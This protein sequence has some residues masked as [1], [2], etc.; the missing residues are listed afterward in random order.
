MLISPLSEIFTVL[1]NSLGCDLFSL[2]NELISETYFTRKELLIV[3]P[4]PILFK[5]VMI[6]Y[7]G[8]C[9]L[10]QHSYLEIMKILFNIA[11]STF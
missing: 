3:Y 1:C 8:L 10:E 11:A 5:V 6:G 2:Y 4:Y 7:I 9:G